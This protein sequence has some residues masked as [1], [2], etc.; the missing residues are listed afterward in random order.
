MVKYNNNFNSGPPIILQP[1]VKLSKE[2]KAEIRKLSQ[3]HPSHALYKDRVRDLFN[4]KPIED[5]T[6][7]DLY[8]LAGFIEGEGSISVGAKKNEC[9]PFGVELDPM[10]NITQHINGVHILY[11]ALEFFGTG[12][13]QYKA[14]SNATLV[15]SIAPRRSLQEK[16]CPFFKKYVYPYSAPAKKRRFNIFKK[17]LDLFD[18]GA[19]LDRNKFAHV[20]LP[21]W[22]AMRIQRGFQNETFKTL[23]EAQD[24]VLNYAKDKLR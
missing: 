7:E 17:M 15:F 10:F 22:D 8:F 2:F 14:G 23:A 21:H 16:V 24:F 9:F 20:L 12:R 4:L 18:Q 3:G 13:I 6:K 11:L 1:G 5:I 19:H